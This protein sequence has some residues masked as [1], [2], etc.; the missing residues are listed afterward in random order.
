MENQ[1][2]RT[3]PTWGARINTGRFGS[4]GGCPSWA[5]RLQREKWEER[6]LVLWDHQA[7]Q[8]TQLSATQT[9]RILEYL[10]A[11]DGWKQ[12]GIIVGEPATRLVLDDPEREP[13]DVLIDQIG[14][15]VSR[16]Q[17]LLELLEANE[18][19]LREIAEAEEKERGRLLG[20]VY[21]H[22]IEIGRR[23]KE[24]VRDSGD[25]NPDEQ[26]QNA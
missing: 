7:Q 5:N 3:E 1:G 6:G 2:D 22:I 20:K 14:L 12:Q 4:Q 17:E 26:G 13:E 18:A 11:D 24:K 19:D 16:V 15:R 21:A 10:R 9:L 25:E 23:N 8:I